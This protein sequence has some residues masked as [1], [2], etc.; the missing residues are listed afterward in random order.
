M[1]QGVLKGLVQLTIGHAFVSAMH[2]TASV[3]GRLGGDAKKCTGMR[4][5]S[6]SLVHLELHRHADMRLT[7]HSDMSKADLMGSLVLPR[8]VGAFWRT[9]VASSSL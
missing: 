5:Q 7:V 3:K 8:G 2:F 4:L 9:S 6:S 1:L